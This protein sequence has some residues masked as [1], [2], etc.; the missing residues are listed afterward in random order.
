MNNLLIENL[1]L[2]LKKGI[3]NK[4]TKTEPRSNHKFSLK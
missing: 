3:T 2:F 1:S 4:E